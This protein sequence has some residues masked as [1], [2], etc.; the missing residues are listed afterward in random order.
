MLDKEK[1]FEDF[2][3]LAIAKGQEVTSERIQIY[4]KVLAE[5]ETEEVS[6]AIMKCFKELK[7]FPDISEVIKFI[8]EPVDAYTNAEI[9]TGEIFDV[10]KRIGRHEIS[11]AKEALGPIAW[12]AVERFGGWD[13]ICNLTYDQLGTARAQLRNICKASMSITHLDANSSEIKSLGVH[14]QRGIKRL[15]ELI[16]KSTNL[17]GQ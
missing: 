11:K 14:G 5:Y 3:M 17:L 7:F 15:D 4:I 16:N 13:T 1:I 6:S 8:R 10:A 2:R 9:M 12:F